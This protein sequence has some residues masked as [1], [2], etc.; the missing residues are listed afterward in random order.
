MTWATEAPAFMLTLELELLGSALLGAVVPT[1][2]ELLTIDNIVRVQ[3]LVSL[4]DGSAELRS[5]EERWSSQW[6]LKLDAPY[7]SVAS[8]GTNQQL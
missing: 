6:T 2:W 5:R 4:C 7:A 8:S 1:L 3:W